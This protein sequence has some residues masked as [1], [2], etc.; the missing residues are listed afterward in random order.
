VAVTVHHTRLGLIN[1]FLIDGLCLSD[2]DLGQKFVALFKLDS[3]VAE[4]KVGFCSS[5]DAETNLQTAI[6]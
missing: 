3:L 1:G 2:W 5:L 6:N 4:W